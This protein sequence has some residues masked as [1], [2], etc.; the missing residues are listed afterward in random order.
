MTLIRRTSCLAA[1]LLA[2]SAICAPAIA[3]DWTL[4][5]NLSETFS[6]ND[7]FDFIKDPDGSVFGLNSKIGLTAEYRSHVDELTLDGALGYQTY[8]G[9]AG[10]IPDD[11]LMPSFNASY[12]RR[13]KTTDFSAGASYVY[14]PASTTNTGLEIPGTEQAGDRA[15]LSAN[16]SVAYKINARNSL[17]LAAR[18]SKTDF[19]NAAPADVPFTTVGSTLTWKRSLSKRVDYSLSNSID[20]YSY[21]DAVNRERLYYVLRGGL[22]ARLSHRLTATAGLGGTLGNVRRDELFPI[23]SRSSTTSVGTLADAGFTYALKTGSIGGTVSYG[24]TPDENGKFSNNLNFGASYNYTV[25]DHT[26]LRL[27]AQYQLSD[28]AINGSLA[29]D[30]F[31]ISPSLSYSLARDW[32]LS[33]SYQFARQDDEQGIAYQNAV[34]LTLSRNYVL[35][36]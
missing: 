34:Y 9:N 5:T 14:E 1:A 32:M 30:T 27:G 21:D 33:A 15:T 12:L 13:G 36:P 17:T 22:S 10:N 20:W 28:S 35:L 2:A 26:S 4:R 11:R 7:N 29:N 24:L 23:G 25:N 16:T 8:F 6:A 18:L 31:S 3:G 19:Y